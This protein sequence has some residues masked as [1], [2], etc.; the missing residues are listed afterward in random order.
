[1][2]APPATFSVD[3]AQWVDEME[4]CPQ[5]GSEGLRGVLKAGGK[6]MWGRSDMTYWGSKS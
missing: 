3:R 4:P 1:M 6:M 5:R 2:D